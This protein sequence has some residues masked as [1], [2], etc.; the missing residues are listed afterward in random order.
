[1][2]GAE[3]RGHSLQTPV[4]KRR[5]RRINTGWAGAGVK[6]VGGLLSRPPI[7][8]TE[9]GAASA[10]CQEGHWRSQPDGLGWTGRQGC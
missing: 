2:R 1:M 10:G 5:S 4:C 6:A 3:S 7:A 8:L 9:D